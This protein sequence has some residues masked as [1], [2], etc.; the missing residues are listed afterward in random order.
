MC[1]TDWNGVWT[2]CLSLHCSIIILSSKVWT[3]LTFF[4]MP[5]QASWNRKTESNYLFNITFYRNSRPIRVQ[6]G[7]SQVSSHPSGTA[8]VHGP[9]QCHK[10]EKA[11]KVSTYRRYPNKCVTSRKTVL[12]ELFSSA[13]FDLPSD[14]CG[15]S[16]ANSIWLTAAEPHICLLARHLPPGDTSFIWVKPQEAEIISSSRPSK[17]RTVLEFQCVLITVITKAHCYSQ[18]KTSRYLSEYCLV[19]IFLGYFVFA[20]SSCGSL[21]VLCLL[22]KSWKHISLIET[23]GLSCGVNVWVNV[24]SCGG[25]T[26]C[27]EW[28]PAALHEHWHKLHHYG[29]VILAK[30]VCKGVAWSVVL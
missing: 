21:R 30:M 11:N 5:I 22:Q 19:E 6:G 13:S 29:A 25:V 9:T 17:F 2:D 28:I 18:L 16:R 7:L 8:E 12:Q 15:L 24:V 27:P 4:K 14:N 3:F 1:D 20:Y 26:T 10:S 23:S